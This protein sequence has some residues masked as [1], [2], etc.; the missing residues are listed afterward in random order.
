MGLYLCIYNVNITPIQLDIQTN[1]RQL[2]YI[3]SGKATNSPAFHILHKQSLIVVMSG[4][5]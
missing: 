3:L 1:E 4:F 2:I 5:S